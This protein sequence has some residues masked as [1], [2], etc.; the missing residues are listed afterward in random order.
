MSKLVG[1][2]IGFFVFA[3]VFVCAV[4]AI[5]AISTGLI[6]LRQIFPGLPE[7]PQIETGNLP[8]PEVEVPPVLQPGESIPL[9]GLVRPR[10]L[11]ARIP[12]PQQLSSDPR[13]IGTNLFLAILMALIFG[14][15]S[16]V[17]GNMLR[18][19]EPRI[20]E[21]LKVLGIERLFGGMKRVFQWSLGHL[22]IRRGCLTLPLVL[23]IFALYGILF[24]FLEEGTSIFSREGVILAVTLAFTAGLVSFGGDIARRIMAWL[25]RKKSRFNL[26][27]ANLM[28]AAGTVILS[29]VLHLSPGIMFGTPGGADVDMPEDRRERREVTLAFATLAVLTLIGAV[30]W[31]VSGVV[32]SLLDVPFDGRIVPLMTN[33]FNLLQN[34]SLALFLTALE[35]LFFESL[36][37]AYG[38]GRT[39]LKWNKIGWAVTFLPIA[40]LFNHAV[41]NPQSGFLDSFMSPNVRFLWF[42]LIVLVGVTA[43]LWFYFNV[44]DDILKQGLG[45]RTPAPTD[46]YPQQPPYDDQRGGGQYPG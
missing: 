6:D 45:V 4:G 10:P 17:L 40:F 2:L 32:L 1:R 44:L 35:T 24:A 46:Q 15:T 18:D 9:Q 20:R 25:W 31:G 14:A 42:V 13:V 12:A 43:G 8:L 39:I 28:V 33:V 30:G 37:L 38:T 41:L 27:P 21:W 36:P 5:L 16:T 29:R 11:F 23:V 19:E 34:T 26:Y 7:P 3:C 22:A